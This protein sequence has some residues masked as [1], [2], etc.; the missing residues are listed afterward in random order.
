M[1][2][3]NL[4]YLTSLVFSCCLTT[5]PLFAK[6]YSQLSTQGFIYQINQ[7]AAIQAQ[8]NQRK[9]DA[10]NTKI[11][12]IQNPTTKINDPIVTGLKRADQRNLTPINCDDP[13]SAYNYPSNYLYNKDQQKIY[14]LHPF[15]KCISTPATQ[16]P[17]TLPQTTTPATTTINTSLPIVGDN[18]LT[19]KN[20]AKTPTNWNINY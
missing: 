6:D 16:Q 5:T 12:K 9:L 15:A 14:Q 8:I 1:N 10:F 20:N 17:T 11:A 7:K 2:F 3:K 13:S 19:N 4:L 18:Q